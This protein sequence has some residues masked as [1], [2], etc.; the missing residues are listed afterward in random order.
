M[1]SHINSTA[2]ISTATMSTP[3]ITPL[4]LAIIPLQVYCMQKQLPATVEDRARLRAC[5]TEAFLQLRGQLRRKERGERF[6]QNCRL[7]VM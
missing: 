6:L 4:N 7:V 1:S 2:T 3:T 5:V